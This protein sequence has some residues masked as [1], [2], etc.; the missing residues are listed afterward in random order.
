[1]GDSGLVLAKRNKETGSVNAHYVTPEHKP[2]NEEEKKRIM[3][4]GGSV[5]TVNGVSR[6]VWKRPI[7]STRSDKAAKFEYIPFLAVSR[8]LGD[9]WSYDREQKNYIVSP[10]PHIEVIDLEKDVDCFMILASDGLWGVMDAQEAIN[11]VDD[12]EK[13]DPQ[14]TDAATNLIHKALARCSGKK[15]KADNISAITVFFDQQPRENENLSEDE[16]SSGFTTV[17]Q[18]DNEE[19]PPEAPVP[20]EVPVLKRTTAI[21]AFD[22]EELR[23]K[24]RSTEPDEGFGSKVLLESPDNSSSISSFPSNGHIGMKRK[25]SPIVT[26]NGMTTKRCRKISQEKC[27]NGQFVTDVSPKSLQSL[28]LD[29]DVSELSPVTL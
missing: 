8:A 3:S 17:P 14:N 1:L 15:A 25:V 24:M 28:K 5:A 26:V 19:T 21:M 18:E 6:V 2:D 29:S 22:F 20:S 7:A 4:L 23:K 10:D 12:Y 13:E 16:L 9:L 27:E 11:I